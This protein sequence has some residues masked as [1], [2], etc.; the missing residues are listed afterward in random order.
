MSG[1]KGTRTK[2]F[3]FER[4]IYSSLVALTVVLALAK[5]LYLFQETIEERNNWKFNISEEEELSEL[6]Q[7]HL[8]GELLGIP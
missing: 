7:F 5:V 4:Q 3:S 2:P 8:V 1:G 6:I